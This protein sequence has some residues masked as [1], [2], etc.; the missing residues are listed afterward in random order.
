MS[1][2]LKPIVLSDYERSVGGEGRRTKD[3]GVGIRKRIGMYTSP[4]LEKRTVIVITPTVV[5]KYH[6][7]SDE[8]PIFPNLLYLRWSMKVKDYTVP[9]EAVGGDGVQNSR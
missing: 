1:V 6:S 9:R 7:T 5:T 8:S 4:D 3:A 2:R